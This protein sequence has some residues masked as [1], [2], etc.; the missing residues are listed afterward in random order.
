MPKHYS[1]YVF[2]DGFFAEGLLVMGV[3]FLAYSAWLIRK[4]IKQHSILF[5]NEK[6]VRLHLFNSIMYAAMFLLSSFLSSWNMLI[7]TNDDFEWFSTE[8]I[9]AMEI[10]FYYEVFTDFADF[11]SVYMDLFLIYLIIRFT[12]N[13]KL[14]LIN[15]NLL[16]REVPSTVFFNN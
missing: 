2:I 4:T 15:D 11:F 8:S 16:G 7:I 14:L 5:P 9:K 13:D 6:L 10:S 12:R 1:M 3:A